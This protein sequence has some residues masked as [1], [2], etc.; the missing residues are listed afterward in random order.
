MSIITAPITVPDNENAVDFDLLVNGEYI[1]AATLL[2][3]E[4]DETLDAW[5]DECNTFCQRAIDWLDSLLVLEGDEPTPESEQARNDAK[6]ALISAA[7]S[8]WDRDWSEWQ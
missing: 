3:R 8:A 2:P 5:G 7:Q 4:W 6:G 1:G